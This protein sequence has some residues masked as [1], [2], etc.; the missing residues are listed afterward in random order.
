MQLKF[1]GFLL[2]LILKEVEKG[3][4]NLQS[5]IKKYL[6]DLTESWADSVTVHQLLNHTHGIVDTEKPLV[7]K[8]GSRF[9]YGNLSYMLLGEILA[10][11]SG[12]TYVELADELFRKL[13]MKILSVII[14]TTSG[15]L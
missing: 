11:V 5:S 7:F 2:T 10:K 1:T 9:K 12:K 13:N 8:P 3:S 15:A 6:P 4:I 14:K